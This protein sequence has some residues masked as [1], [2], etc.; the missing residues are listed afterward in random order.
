MAVVLQM[1]RVLAERP[2][3][4][5][6][7]GIAL[8]HFA[9][10]DDVELWLDVRRRAFARERYGVRDWNAADFAREFLDKAWWQPELMWFAVPADSLLIQPKAVG[11]V[12]LARRGNTT[13][14]K[15]VVHWLAVLPAWRRRNVGRLLM[16]AVEAACWDAGDRQVWLE[17]HAAWNAA[18]RFYESL[19]YRAVGA[20]E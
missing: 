9:G 17:T 19:G 10:P 4:L 5:S 18:V 3:A 12:T 13:E 15:P 11:T 8:R 14:A 20:G 6:V 1:S 7:P 16:S 2:A